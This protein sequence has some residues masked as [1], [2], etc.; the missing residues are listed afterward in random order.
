MKVALKSK[1]SSTPSSLRP[2]NGP[3]THL[4]HVARRL[5]RA[6]A[7]PIS[8]PPSLHYLFFPLTS[9]GHSSSSPKPLSSNGAPNL[10]PDLRKC[11]GHNR[12]DLLVRAIDPT[13]HPQ[14]PNEIDGRSPRRDDVLLV[15][16][17]GTVWR[18]RHRAALQH[19]HPG[20]AAVPLRALLGE[21]GAV[22][23]L[24]ARLAD[25]DDVSRDRGD[26]GSLCGRADDAGFGHQGA[27]SSGS[28]VAGH[29][30][31]DPSGRAADFGVRACAI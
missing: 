10:H 25:L 28:G 5:P 23:A 8:T 12:H 2:I 7:P 11:A 17:G 9:L 14:S 27:V 21:L 31:G 4:T 15:A 24:R 22:H 3:P 20:T 30:R 1:Y 13:N 26:F 6:P 29:V 18:L 16:L 19:P